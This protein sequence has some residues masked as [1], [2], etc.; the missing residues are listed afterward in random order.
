MKDPR[1]LNALNSSDA[2]WQAQ[3]DEEL[4]EEFTTIGDAELIYSG[5]SNRDTMR[6]TLS[7]LE[8]IMVSGDVTGGDLDDNWYQAEV[9]GEEAVGGQTPTPDQNVTEQLLQAMGID[10]VDGEL[11]QVKEK[12][13]R[14]DRLRWE[15]EPESAEDYQERL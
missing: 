8:A 2:E 5:L 10:T 4:L 1:N 15:L 14:R 13:E 9:V 7:K 11:V 6:R 3:P 12:L